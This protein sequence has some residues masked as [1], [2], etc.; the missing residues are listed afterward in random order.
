MTESTTDSLLGGRVIYRQPARGYRVAVEAPLLAAFALEPLRRAVEHAVDL[1][2]G[3]GAVA[4]MLLAT[5]GCTRAT[6]VEI[7]ALHASLA[8]ENGRENKFDLR[9]VESDVALAETEPAALVVA[10]PP[11]F[12]PDRGDIAEDPTRAGARA[13]TRGTLDAF[14]KAARR[15][16]VPRGRV[17]MSMP[18]SRTTE[19]LAVLA[20][21][22][23]HG[24]RMRFVHARPQREAN[25][26]FVEARPAKPGGLVIE[27]PLFVRAERGEEYTTEVVEILQGRAFRK[28][29][30]T[31]APEAGAQRSERE[32]ESDPE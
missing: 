18:S 13:F 6:A 3:P 23:L 31:G 10:N 17:T 21:H 22:G 14:V 8:R 7:D 30:A 4:L 2:S 28:A 29:W 9:V 32:G 20:A 11:W 1:G 16:V 5:G 26:V 19:L 25:V 27:R 24:K 15:I 12:E